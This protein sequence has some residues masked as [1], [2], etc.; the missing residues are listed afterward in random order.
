MKVRT[1]KWGTL[2]SGIAL[3]LAICLIV[4]S[5]H[6]ALTNVAYAVSGKNI[7]YFNDDVNADSIG[8]NDFDFGPDRKVQADEAVASGEAKSIQ[9]WVATREG[10]GDFFESIAIDPALC[11][12]VAVH[13][14]ESLALPEVILYDEQDVIIGQRANEAHRHFL[15]DQG[16]W[17]ETVALIV[18]Y[19]SSSTI[20][21][22]RSK[23][24]TVGMYM[25]YR[26]LD[27]DKP[28]VIV[29]ETDDIGGRVILFDLGKPGSVKFEL[30]CGYQPV[31]VTYWPTPDAASQLRTI[32][33]EPETVK[34]P[35]VEEPKPT[36]ISVPSKAPAKVT[37]EPFV[38]TV[39]PTQ[40]PTV[41][42]KKPTKAPEHATYTKIGTIG[43]YIDKE[44]VTIDAYA[45]AGG[46]FEDD[47]PRYADAVFETP[48]SYGPSLLGNTRAQTIA[49][50]FHEFPKSPLQV[51]RVMIQTGLIKLE[52]LQS[53]TDYAYELIRLTADEYDTV[54]NSTLAHVYNNLNGGKAVF[55]TDW[56]LEN[57]MK[58][59]NGKTIL[60]GRLNGDD[61]KKKEDKDQLFTFFNASGSNFV[62]AW[63]GLSNTARDAKQDP[64]DFA[65]RAWINADEGGTWKWK[66]GEVKVTETPP[67]PTNTPSPTPTNTPS[68]TP[69]N[70]P[71]PTPTN[72]PSPSPSPSPTPTNTP[73]PS[74][75]PTPTPTPTPKPSP[76]PTPLQTKDPDAGPQGQTE[77][78][79]GTEDFG[80]GQNHDPDEGLTEE[81][82]SPDTYVPPAPPEPDPTAAPT[83]KP[84]EKPTQKPTE[85]PTQKPTEK[86]TASPSPVPVVTATPKPTNTPKPTPTPKP[87]EQVQEEEHSEQTVEESLQGDGLNEG[88][89]DE[90]QVE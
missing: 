71:S 57:M 64:R 32:I 39:E 77:D 27:G 9:E 66:R 80:G 14:D 74:P 3:V 31:D 84:T 60:F 24:Y 51:V 45:Y 37:D 38:P 75:S 42:T 78:E 88:D 21:I 72:T 16:Y 76:T 73:S 89:L 87:L 35:V 56:T 40:A 52:P 83:Q 7:H 49:N 50:W 54:V 48:E 10:T 4:P 8:N 33:D 47:D 36:P 18:R 19:L 30:D 68:P 58:E 55:S 53:E 5:V 23:N 20:S 15:R 46:Y 13:L 81:P 44:Y 2:I 17:D 69:T 86:P 63:V 12:A 41:P 61:D 11:A 90:S 43:F 79:P 1:V 26:G 67:P 28:S 82:E 70:T 22:Q 59:V 34:A 25:W 85:K 65:N 62:S 29:H 6:A